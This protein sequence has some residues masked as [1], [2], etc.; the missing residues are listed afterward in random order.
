MRESVVVFGPCAPKDPALENSRWVA[1]KHAEIL[2][3]RGFPLVDQAATRAAL[4][5]ALAHPRTAG[6]VLCGH[7][8]G[9]KDVFVL[10][11]QHHDRDEEWHR[12]HADTSDHGAVYGSDGE[13]ALDAKNLHLITDRWIHVLACEVGL[14]PLP[15]RAREIGAL[16]F[17]AYEQRLVPEFTVDALPP[18]AAALLGEL[19]TLATR[20]MA[21]GLFDQLLLAREVR[22]ASEALDEWFDSDE[23]WAW[24]IGPGAL[25]RVGLTKFAKQLSSALRV[26]LPHD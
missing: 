22:R 1:A 5:E 20:R 24:T 17:A 6:A 13:A 23:G 8:D 10:F 11:N 15:V 25:E 9:G 19:V 14:S 26:V 7:G 18:K 2:D 3:E 12:R 21:E 4:E 16:A